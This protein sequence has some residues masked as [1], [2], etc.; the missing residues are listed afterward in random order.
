MENNKKS[1]IIVS[2]FLS[3]FKVGAFT[4]G[5]GYAMIALLQNEFVLKKKWID[6]KEFLDIVA[7][8]E[9]TP[10]PI[11][12][13]AATYIGYKMAG[14]AG[15]I[16]S[17]I[18]VA[19]PSLIIIYIISLFFD[20]FLKIKYVSYAF[21]GV[22]AAVIYLILS[23]AVKMFKS[24]DKS[25]FNCFLFGLVLI[26]ICGFSF[27]KISFSSIYFIL[28]CGVAGI[29]LYYVKRSKGGDKK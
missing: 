21:K 23:A 9:S 4:F 1:K 28:I 3:F 13:N 6:E 25:I 10:G 2:L 26:C 7:I 24:L 20:T 19:L 14:I 17:T 29:I 22:S 16:F 8:A 27:Y 11:A 5:G 15:S 12:I 18:G